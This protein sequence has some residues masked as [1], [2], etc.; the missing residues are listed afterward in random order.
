MTRAHAT[1][2]KRP[3]IGLSDVTPAALICSITG[4]TS[5]ANRSASAFLLATAAGSILPAWDCRAAPGGGNFL[6]RCAA[7][8]MLPKCCSWET[9]DPMIYVKLLII[10]TNF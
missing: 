1:G 8:H 10:K 5:A 7:S 6:F 4:M 3:S 9:D 2:V